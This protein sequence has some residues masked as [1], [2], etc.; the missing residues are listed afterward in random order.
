MTLHRPLFALT[1]LLA[2]A[3]GAAAGDPVGWGG[4]INA[5]TGPK[6]IDSVRGDLAAMVAAAPAERAALASD[7]SARRGLNAIEAVKRFRNPELVTL[8][9]VLLDH[10]DWRV[11]HRALHAL[12]FYD[13]EATLGRA[14]AL[15]T[16]ETPR[17]R[18][19]AAI[20]CIKLWHPARAKAAAGGDPVAA[21]KTLIGRETNAH[22]RACL[23]V[24]V[25][26]ATGK[27][28]SRR[29]HEEHTE[30]GKDGLQLTPFLSGMNTAR[31]V[32][33]GY[34]AKGTSRGGGGSAAKLGPAPRWTTPILG[35]GDEEVDGTSLQ[36]FAN[37]RGGGKTYHTGLDLGACLDGAGYY[38]AAAGVVR[39]V[40]SGSD[41]GTLIVVQH[42]PEGKRLVNA[43]YMH[44]GDTV[45]VDGG[46]KVKA[47]QL[48]GT[49]GLSYSIENG[50]HY[51]HLHYGL[52]PGA[53]SDT[54]NYGYKSVAAGL[55]DW[56]DPAGF[57]PRWIDRTVPL[58]PEFRAA[59]P[60]L[61][62]IVQVAHKGSYAKA[63]KSLGQLLASE[64]LSDETRA[65]AKRLREA[66]DELAGG[67]VRR[68]EA[69][70]RAGYP[71]FATDL[72]SSHERGVKGLP[73]AELLSETLRAWKKDPGF[74]RALKGDGKIA[75]AEEKAQKLGRK[76][77]GKDDVAAL[78][79]KLLEQYGDTCLKPRLEEK[80]RFDK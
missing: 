24:L 69:Q 46:A 33:P 77:G 4:D 29:V 22:V 63:W 36:P 52:Y 51:S 80:L 72:L 49:M 67:L 3:S 12:E 38:A 68:G 21:L 28:K 26:R 74:A 7:F 79:K 64:G 32:A 17:L 50:G 44:G 40:H 9:L 18:E 19:K 45:F 73:G 23:D 13:H 10:D 5:G 15:L 27:L 65:G 31:K 37:L 39:L 1:A 58:L 60:A 78:W 70:V 6:L 57:L 30:T 8:F 54:H 14:W 35:F 41:M 20:T 71:A 43:V 47:G 16:H 2:L 75:A 59:G 25:S 66:L 76:K 62:K 34:S 56:I 61:A 11:R 48:L 53:Y 42:C 55:A